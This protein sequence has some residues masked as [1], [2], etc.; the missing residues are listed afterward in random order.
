MLRQVS[1]APPYSSPW[2]SLGAWLLLLLLV[3]APALQAQPDQDHPNWVTSWS[4]SPSTLPVQPGQ[5][6]EQL[7]K[8]TLRVIVHTSA[9]GSALRLRI[10]N[11]HGTAPL[12]VGAVSVG[13]QADGSAVVPGSVRNVTFSKKR[14]F[15]LARGAV[16]ISDPIAFDVPQSGNLSV[17]IYLPTFS[18]FVTSHRA[19]LQTN[20]LSTSGN[21][22]GEAFQVARAITHSSLLTA[23]DVLTGERVGT[24]VA[25]GD[26]I[27]D[28][29]GSSVDANQRWPNLLAQRI[30]ADRRTP[31]R[32]VTIAAIAGNRVTTEASPNFGENLQARFQRDV[33]NLANVSHII[34]LEGI[35]DI[36]MSSRT[37]VLISA[38][39]I[40]D[41]YRQIIAR[42]H[43]RGIKVIAGLLLPYEGAA[44]YTQ[45]GNAVREA[46]NHF[47]LT[48]GEFDG[49][50]DFTAAVAD[51]ANT[52]HLRSEFTS[53]NLHP[54]DAGY[55]AMAEAIPLRLFR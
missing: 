26:S 41:G 37:G 53:D 10:S 18:G 47:I 9:G 13:L 27:T 45:A 25:V 21:Y 33:L 2:R 42:A 8:Q 40:I 5:D 6:Y 29:T 52:N 35:N 39:E 46:V 7:F 22:T 3:A 16:M 28:G 55:K 12:K 38:E 11:T 54:N 23:V 4:A 17:S 32:A 19:A 36:G 24:I 31:D 14:G 50:I 1:K 34:L 43:A 48:S 51:P 44:Y 15:T 30:Y 20:Y 49:V